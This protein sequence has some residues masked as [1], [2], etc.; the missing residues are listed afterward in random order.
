MKKFVLAVVM[1][2]MSLGASAQL[3]IGG[4]LNYAHAKVGEAKANTI[5]IAPEV[6]YNFS[7][8]IGVGLNLA[9]SVTKIKDVDANNNAFSVAPFVRY[10]FANPTEN[11]SFFLDG[12]F[13]VSMLQGH[14]NDDLFIGIAPGLK[15][16][17]SEKWS[18]VT[19]LGMIGWSKALVKDGPSVFDLGV[20]GSDLKFGVIY[21]F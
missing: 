14:D 19:S 13:G 1:A 2:A 9:Y 11:L 4:G 5:S 8:K 20:N 17:V 10:T 3:W 18:L 7:E 16:N 12:G 15:Y 6:G 21:T